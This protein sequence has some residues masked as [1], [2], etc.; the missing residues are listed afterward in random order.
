MFHMYLWLIFGFV[1]YLFISL[2]RN[3]CFVCWF[4]LLVKTAKSVVWELVKY[5]VKPLKQ[6]TAHPLDTF[7]YACE[8]KSV[9]C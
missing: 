6:V 4:F 7:P 3:V 8:M 2:F 1:I 9:I 5:W